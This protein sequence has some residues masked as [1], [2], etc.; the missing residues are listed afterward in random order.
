M[1][2]YVVRGKGKGGGV[3]QVWDGSGRLYV[4]LSALTYSSDF[5]PISWPRLLWLVAL[6][7][8][9]L[10]TAI[11]PTTLYPYLFAWPR[12]IFPSL[13]A[14]M[15]ERKTTYPL[16]ATT[17]HPLTTRSPPPYMGVRAGVGGAETLTDW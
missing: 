4:V 15:P 6:Q 11:S 9:N 8:I 14:T 13:A 17:P 10:Y 3:L 12:V 1:V 2:A 5:F 16:P 7:D